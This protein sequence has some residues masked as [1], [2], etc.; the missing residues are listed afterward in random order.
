MK[1]LFFAVLALVAFC[2]CNSEKPDFLYRGLSTSL[3]LNAFI[4][5]LAQRGFV[6]DSAASPDSTGRVVVLKSPTEKYHV[7]LGQADG[8][9]QAVQENWT[10][11][12]NDS[13]RQMW[14]Q[15]HDALEEQLDAW[16]N[17]LKDGKDHRIAKFEDKG[18][19]ITLTLENTYKP[20]LSVLY[21]SK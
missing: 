15:M 11:S 16:P 20:T 6:V 3:P 10:L 13:T 5:S 12:T 1:K 4:D 2:A 7:L 17:M 21:Q 18:G 19:F 8:M 9:I 14:Q